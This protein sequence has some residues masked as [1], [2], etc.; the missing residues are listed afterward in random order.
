MRR[1]IGM[2]DA[3]KGSRGD[4]KGNNLLQRVRLP[5]GRTLAGYKPKRAPGIKWAVWPASRG[6]R[7][8]FA[9]SRAENPAWTFRG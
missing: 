5:G 8:A 6:W 9:L 2:E 4:S 1:R 7:W 3:A